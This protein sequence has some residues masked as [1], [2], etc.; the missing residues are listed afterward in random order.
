[1]SNDNELVDEFENL[2]KQK[3][4]LSKEAAEIRKLMNEWANSECWREQHD[5]KRKAKMAIEK[6]KRNVFCYALLEVQKI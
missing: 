1:M 3:K 5:R 4:E 6:A 2:E